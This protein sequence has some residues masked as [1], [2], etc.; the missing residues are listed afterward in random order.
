M[1]DVGGL[2]AL[3]VSS[4]AFFTNYFA[5]IRIDAIFAERGY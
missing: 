4:L 2:Y 3:V 5:G 1:G